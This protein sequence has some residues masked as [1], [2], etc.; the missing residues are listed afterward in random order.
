MLTIALAAKT[1][2]D[3]AAR[4]IPAQEWPLLGSVAEIGIALL[5]VVSG[6]FG[7]VGSFGLVKLPDPMTR[8]HAPTK[9]A[10]LGV[11]SVL[12]ASMLNFYLF[13][14]VFTWHELLISIFLFLT[15]PITGNFI[16]KAHLH[17]AWQ[18][19]EIP[20]PE[21][22]VKWATYGCADEEEGVREGAEIA[23]DRNAR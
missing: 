11:G 16:A 6:I 2:T 20:R 3:A 7:L 22:D 8:L 17:L 5:L 4:T 9:A 14:G 10:T 1:A 19:D 15:A 23:S 13:H 12:I 18:Q 21:L